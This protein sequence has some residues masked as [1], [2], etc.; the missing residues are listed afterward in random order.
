M[1]KT[2]IIAALAASLMATAAHAGSIK[3]EG[4]NQL[5][6]AERQS[7]KIEV[8][9]GLTGPVGVG[10]EVK[11]FVAEGNQPAASNIVGK[12]G[13]AF[14]EVA[15]FTPVLKGEVGVRTGADNAE[16][17]GLGLDLKRP[18][19]QKLSATV[20]FRHREGF[21]N[22][23]ANRDRILAGLE[24]AVAKNTSLGVTY[25]NYRQDDV[26]TGNGTSR[27]DSLALSLTK[28]F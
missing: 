7:V 10:F 24:Y 22:S 16:F 3:I 26:A 18:L 12:L 6:G 9:E 27:T 28:K 2:T 4:E 5:N 20:G 21:N 13:Y 8:W 23:Y 19:T 17:W 11:T 1:K 14:P 25:F 15:G